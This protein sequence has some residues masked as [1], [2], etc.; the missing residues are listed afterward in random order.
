MT[1][2]APKPNP[3]GKGLSLIN[4][5]SETSLT[6]VAVPPKN[7]IQVANELFTSMF[8]LGSDF[9]FKPVIGKEYWLYFK[10]PRFRLSLIS[11]SE[12]RDETF[13]KLVGNCQLQDDLTWTLQL[14]EQTSRDKVLMHYIENKRH[15]FEENLN[16]QDSLAD[17]LPVYEAKLPFY[18]RLYAS[19]LSKSLGY[20]MSR[21]GI[22]GLNYPAA[23]SLDAMPQENP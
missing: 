5:I 17:A 18:Q 16:Q 6:L 21:S 19:M 7:A 8:V 9:G 23:L 3:Q 12:W 20:S 13:G 14:S 2:E 15:Q 22:A 11:P 10:S 4:V 1:V